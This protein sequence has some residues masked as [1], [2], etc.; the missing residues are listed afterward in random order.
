VLDGE[1]GPAFDIV[2][3]NAGAALFVAGA[4]HD[5]A[6][7]VAR[8]RESVASGAAKAKLA[9]LAAATQAVRA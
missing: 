7:G 2:L 4:A 1:P 5:I 6:S 3:V 8:A 9:A